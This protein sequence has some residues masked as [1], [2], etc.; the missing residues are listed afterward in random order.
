MSEKIVFYK[1]QWPVIEA[2]TDEEAG[3]ILKAAFTHSLELMPD[4][5][6]LKQ[7][8]FAEDQADR[9]LR[10]AWGQCLTKLIYNE[11]EAAKRSEK[12][13]KAA[14]IRWEKEKAQKANADASNSMQMHA[15]ASNSMRAN[16][17]APTYTKTG[18]KTIRDADGYLRYEDTGRLVSEGGNR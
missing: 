10:M 1:D 17:D 15:N 4:E 11:K 13:S 2:L 14:N 12:L 5:E 3:R 8:G 7:Y 18:R 9:A 16:A 6:I